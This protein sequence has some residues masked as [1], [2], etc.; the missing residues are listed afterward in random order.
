MRALEDLVRQNNE[1]IEKGLKSLEGKTVPVEHAY[2][3]SQINALAE[4]V[5][6][7]EEAV[8]KLTYDGE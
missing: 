7:L 6:E 1:M 5:A 4:R 3:Q 8:R 2:L